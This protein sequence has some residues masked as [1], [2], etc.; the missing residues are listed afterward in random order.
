MSVLR[1]PARPV[2]GQL[3][4]AYLAAVIALAAGLSEALEVP[5]LP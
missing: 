2:V 3:P 5:T 4:E 1:P